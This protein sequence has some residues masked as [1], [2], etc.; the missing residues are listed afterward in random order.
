MSGERKIDSFSDSYPTSKCSNVAPVNYTLV[1]S[2]VWSEL[3]KELLC[4]ECRTK[5]IFI[6]FRE[7]HGFSSKIIVKCRNCDYVSANV[8]SSPR[9]KNN[10]SQ[11]PA[12]HVNNA[13]VETFST[14]GKGQ[15]GLEKFSVGMGMNTLGP[16]PFSAHLKLLIDEGKLMRKEVLDMAAQVVRSSHGANDN[17]ILDICVSYDASWHKRGH[18]SNYGVGFAIDIQTGIVLDYHVLSKYCQKCVVA[19][20]DLGKHSS[21]FDIWYEGH[22]NSSECEKNYC[23]SSNA[24]EKD[25]GEIL[26]RRSLGKGFRYTTMLSDGDA[27][28]HVHLNQIQVYGPGITIVKEECINHV[29]KR[30]G[31]ALR[32]T[33]RD[34]KAKGETLGGRKEGSLTE[35]T[36]TKLGHYFR[37]AIVN[38]IPDVAKMKRAIYSTLRH[39]MSTDLNPQHIT[40][41]KGVDSWCF[42]NRQQAEGKPVDS[43][44]RMTCKLRPSVVTKIAPVYQRLASDEMLRRCC[45]GKT[46]NANESLH[47]MVW[48]KCPK[49]VFISKS[50]LEL[51]ILRAVSEFNMGHY[52]TAETLHAIRNSLLSSTTQSLCKSQDNRR[53]ARSRKRTSEQHK[54]ERK[55]HKLVKIS[56]EERFRRSEGATYAAGQF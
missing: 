23:G 1:H 15:R 20:R 6:Q 11:R 2:D 40:C 17:E 13:M 43:H 10:N 3:V 21:E 30:L 5:S 46:Q 19:E 51:G 48:S 7:S 27:K 9:V 31:T 52:K 37:H 33:V 18:T 25:I 50:K 44:S 38:N 24:M 39:C 4:G 26:W 56:T 8:Y 49:E 29:S 41:P 42:F 22:N 36:M 35:T 47:S 55:H 12:F 14:L 32:N 53:V 34:W 16:R 54:K 45:A 28:T